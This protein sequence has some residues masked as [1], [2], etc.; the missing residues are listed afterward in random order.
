MY[1]TKKRFLTAPDGSPQ[2]A[3]IMMLDQGDNQHGPFACVLRNWL[4]ESVTG[5]TKM[6]FLA[7]P[8][9]ALHGSPG[10]RK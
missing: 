4:P 5:I 8:A 7:E 10:L 2:T 3:K 6:R 1:I 9:A